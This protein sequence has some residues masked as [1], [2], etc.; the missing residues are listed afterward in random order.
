MMD[1]NAQE[2]LIAHS[3]I[4]EIVKKLSQNPKKLEEVLQL[5]REATSAA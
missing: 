4:A 2:D 1:D 3:A 5:V